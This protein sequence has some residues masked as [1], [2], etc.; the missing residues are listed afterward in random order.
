MKICFLLPTNDISGGIFT[1]YEHARRLAR[2]GHQAVIAF[3]HRSSPL[4]ITLYPGMELVRTT[5]LHDID[6]REEFD[7]ACATWWETAYSIKRIRAKCY[8]YFVQGFEERFYE[9]S[10]VST[11]SRVRKTY[12]ENAHLFTVTLALRRYL[13]DEFGRESTLVRNSVDVQSFERAIPR[14]PRNGSDRIRVLVEGCGPMP[15]KRIGLAFSVLHDVP[16][17]ETVYLN[18]VGWREPS[19]RIDHHCT[20]VP[21]DEVPGIYASCD[22]LLKL[23]SEE[24]FSRPVL[25]MFASGG[26]AIVSAFQG[27]AEYIRHGRNALVVPIDDREAAVRA[28]RQ[29]VADRD[30]RTR[31]QAG[32]RE[33]LREFS[34]DDSNAVLE[35]ALREMLARHRRRQQ[36]LLWK[37]RSRRMWQAVSGIAAP[38]RSH[39]I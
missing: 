37:A 3:E 6:E 14:I 5:R 39:V 7:A 38:W 29:V 8:C 32:A 18:P 12:E 22:V 10:D 25:E 13:R 30:L 24:S 21:Y 16:E 36:L 15:F 33:T 17:A 28:L 27:H 26:T 4:R 23:S 31:L 1:V 34:W 9:P 2:K 11:R 35:A 20:R 19:W